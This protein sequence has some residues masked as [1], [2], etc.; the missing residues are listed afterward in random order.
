MKKEYKVKAP[1]IILA[2]ISVVE[3]Q[4]S[5]TLPIKNFTINSKFLILLIKIS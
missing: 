4:D 3:S 1:L 2:V 5:Q